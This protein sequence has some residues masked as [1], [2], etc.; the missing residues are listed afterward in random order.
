MLEGRFSEPFEV[1]RDKFVEGARVFEST[2]GASRESLGDSSGVESVG[3]SCLLETRLSR[4]LA[5]P[6]LDRL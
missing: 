1:A 5:M 4:D 3:T 2:E 6:D